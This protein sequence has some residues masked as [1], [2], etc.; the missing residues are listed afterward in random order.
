MNAASPSS[1]SQLDPPSSPDLKIL[2]SV[3][4]I[5]S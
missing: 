2:S 3:N 5:M 1:E 4:G